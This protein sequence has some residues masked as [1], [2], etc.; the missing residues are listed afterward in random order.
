MTREKC[1][2]LKELSRS[3]T[4]PEN[5]RKNLLAE[6]AFQEKK[7][8]EE[9]NQYRLVKEFNTWSIALGWESFYDNYIKESKY[10]F[11]EYI[12]DKEFV[13]PSPWV[14][15]LANMGDMAAIWEMQKRQEEIEQS[16]NEEEER[17][18]NLLR[19]QDR[20]KK[21]ILEWNDK[22]DKITIL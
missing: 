13:T 1:K 18:K 6:L 7:F 10:T 21:E 11:R 12:Q 15:K 5:Q 14:K 19:I 4:M 9:K 8:E 17:T 22:K 20:R 16:A 3:A 2:K